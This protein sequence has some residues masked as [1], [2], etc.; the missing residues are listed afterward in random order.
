MKKLY[1]TLIFI[2]TLTAGVNAQTYPTTFWYNN[3][4]TSWYNAAQTEYTITTASAL[5]GIAEL[6]AQGNDLAGKTFTIGANIDLDA[7][8][9]TPI[10]VN[11]SLPFSGAVDGGSYTITNLW[12]NT[13]NAGF[14]GLFGQVTSGSLSNIKIDAAHITA[15]DTAGV[16]VGNFS[17]NSSIENCHVT[18]ASVIGDANNDDSYNIGGLIG[19]LLIS[20]TMTK[21][22][23][24]GD[25]VGYS[26][27]GGIVG[28]AWDTTSITESYSKGSVS[29]GFLIGG[30]VGYC[31]MSFTPNSNNIVDN[32]YSRSNITAS[33]GR[34]GGVYGG[35]DSNLILNNSYATGV[36]SAPEYQG[37]VI[38]AWGTGSIVVTNSYFDTETSLLTEG[39]GGFIGEPVDYEIEGRTTA[40]MKTTDL[41]DLLNAGSSDNPWTISSSMNDGYPVLNSL[42]SVSDNI[43]EN[44][45]V[46][47]TVFTNEINIDAPY[48]A[49]LK[50]F[51]MYNT[52][53]ALIF[54]GDLT[55]TNRIN[56]TSL[57]EGIYFLN[58]TTENGMLTKKVI[59]Q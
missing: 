2:L 50:S 51:S 53:G 13:P 21:C 17:T 8:L 41:V 38:G 47:P 25:V 48:S 32:C 18:N 35:S 28:S 34:A 52:T 57:S 22:S 16:L 15:L 58:I 29:G 24:D 11:V 5:A 54:E 12:I 43:L 3:T 33:F 6:V 19:G 27:I 37:G 36:V 40:D 1:T 9:W 56:T 59:K 46:Y 45:A 42:L 20:S 55:Q 31:T 30:V 44:A 49:Q 4:D 26:Q 39:V 10:G 7:H 23:F 14:A